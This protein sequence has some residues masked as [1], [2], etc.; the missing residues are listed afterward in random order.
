MSW[1]QS[2]AGARAIPSLQPRGLWLEHPGKA[3]SLHALTIRD[4][5]RA[6]STAT[7][8]SWIRLRL[9]GSGES[10]YA[11]RATDL[12]LRKDY[13]ALT[14]GAGTGSA[15]QCPANWHRILLPLTQRAPMARLSRRQCQKSSGLFL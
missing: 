9:T 2:T 13:S 12:D 4:T 6:P 8:S 5:R 10:S 11:R 1:F 3:L 15:S 7:D 14:S